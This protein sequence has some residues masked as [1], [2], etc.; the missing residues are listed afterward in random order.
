[1]Q[2]GETNHKSKIL[3]KIYHSLINR[4]GFQNWWPGETKDEII[5]GA[6][7]TQ[8]V[9]W[10]NVEKAID[11]LKENKLCSLS[12][13]KNTDQETI[14][15]LIKSTLYYNQKAKKLHNFISHLEK[16]Y[17]GKLEKLFAL[18]VNKLRAELLKIKGI[19]KETAD[20]I[21]LYAAEKPIFVIDSYTKRIFVRLGL[22]K[23]DWNYQ[24]LQNFFQTELPAKTDLFQDFHAQIVKLAKSYCTKKQPNCVNCPIKEFCDYYA[25]K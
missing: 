23:D 4:F 14:A 11:I 22:A 1:M 12:K 21:I 9:S 13:L 5:I 2:N 16:K 18:D 7:L 25:E 20:S 8:S 24:I 6:I 19:G 17:A 10:K 15:S 3:E